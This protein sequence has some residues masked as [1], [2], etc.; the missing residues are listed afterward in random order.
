M[1]SKTIGSIL[2]E[3]GR[4]TEE[5]AEQVVVQQMQDN[6]RFGDAAMHLGFISKED[7]KFAIS[8]QFD[9]SYLSTTDDSVDQCLISAFVTD[10]PQVEAFKSLRSQLSLRWFEENKSIVVC[11]PVNGC[12]SSYVSANLSVLFAQAGKKTLLVDANFRHPSQHLCFRNNNKY[13]FSQALA[14][15]LDFNSIEE[16][17]GLKNLNVLFSGA[18][19]PNPVELLETSNFSKERILIE[20]GFDVVIYDAPPI[21]L[22]TET[23]LLISSIGGCVLVGKRE[24][25][26]ISD[27]QKAKHKVESSGGVS[28]GVVVNEFKYK[29]L[30]GRR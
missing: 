25:T 7:V 29:K 10:G 17:P 16:I 18:M 5:Q 1:K 14:G 22:Y 21:N 4:I 6:S 13:G 23:Q 15:N 30:S 20:E 19:P 3:S 2:L 9:F 28:L 24:T 12:G 27:L 26:K 11:S 8:K